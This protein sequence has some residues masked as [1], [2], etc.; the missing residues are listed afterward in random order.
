MK[1][2][3]L[4]SIN[5]NQYKVVIDPSAYD[6][7]EHEQFQKLIRKRDLFP[8]EWL[9]NVIQLIPNNQQFSSYDHYNMV[10]YVN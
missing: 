1:G 10:L 7:S 4:Q 5:Q 8:N 3:S 9:S 6:E 2:V